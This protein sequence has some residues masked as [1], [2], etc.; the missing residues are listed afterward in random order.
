MLLV[1]DYLWRTARALV[2]AAAALFFTML[3]PDFHASAPRA[4]APSGTPTVNL[5]VEQKHIVKELVKELKVPPVAVDAP[6]GV[7][8]VVPESVVAQPIPVEVAQR[9]PQIRSHAF[10]VK[11]DHIVLVNPKDRR[12]SD[13][14]E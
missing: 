9:V 11:G 8:Q 10:F 4:Q 2:V 7:G 12:V 13:V 3:G 14:I 5:T 1:V 6:S